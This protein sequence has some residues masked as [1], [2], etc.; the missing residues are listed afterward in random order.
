MKNTIQTTARIGGALYFINIVFGIFAIGYISSS[1]IMGDNAAATA[2]NILSNESLY[3]LGLVFHIIILLT[4]IPLAVIFYRLFKVVNRN[5][6][7]LV[8]FFTLVGTAIEA[9][10]LLNEF[11]PLILLKG[12]KYSGIFSPGELQS[13][14]HMLLRLKGVGFNLALVFFGFYCISIGYLI[15]KSTFLPKI[16]GVL[17][18]IGGTCYLLNSFTNFLAPK[19]ARSLV[20]Y[21]L[22]P[23]G[24]AEL[25]LCLWLLIGGV[26][27]A[28]WEQ[29][30]SKEN[31]M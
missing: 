30:A 7:L 23:S 22:I 12:D 18:A 25:L 3:R 6:T 9:V 21:I 15:F 24:L 14:T 10:N 8:V 28:R 17:M 11:A 5:A 26:N 13:W 1:I 27:V 19:F 20:P 29:K 31:K 4:N 16:I 2:H